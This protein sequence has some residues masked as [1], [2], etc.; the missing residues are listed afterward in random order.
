MRR[1]QSILSYVLH[2]VCSSAMTATECLSKMVDQLLSR[3][4]PTLCIQNP[5]GTGKTFLLK[6]LIR[7]LEKLLGKSARVC[8]VTYRTTL[9][10]SM[11][12]SLEDLGFINYLDM[13]GTDKLQ[14]ADKC[15][16]QLDSIGMVMRSGRI[17]P[18]YDLVVLDESESTLHHATARKHGVRQRQTFDAFCSIVKQA[19]R[20]LVM[21]AL[22]GRETRA[23]LR[24][25]GRPPRVVRNT[26]RSDTPRVFEFTNDQ[27]TWAS[28][29]VERLR[30]GHNCAVAS[31][32]ATKL[33]NLKAY[34]VEQGVLEWEDILIY[35]S[36]TNDDIKMQVRDVNHHW[37][38]Y[39][40]VMWSPAVEAW[41]DFVPHFHSMFVI[42]S[43]MSTVA[44]G[45]VQS[46]GRIRTL[47]NQHVMCLCK[48]HIITLISPFY[49]HFYWL[50]RRNLRNRAYNF[51]GLSPI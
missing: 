29:L 49:A 4:E 1:Q 27:D 31:M 17:I 38:K 32:S 13:K 41:V 26:W 6:K 16:V 45:L 9:S 3:E 50:E 5:M 22:L 10:L 43:N 35:D 42:V 14:L 44:M 2:E 33:H 8:V 12:A 51:E 25:L 18:H 7:E 37:V 20:L 46:Q 21:D 34:L 47:E 39:R 15:I 28:E 30:Q 19:D 24:S 36:Q 23:Y 40:L 11:L 48:L